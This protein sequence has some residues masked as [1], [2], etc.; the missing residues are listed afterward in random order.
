[1]LP[2]TCSKEE[3]KLVVPG[4]STYATQ[5]CQRDGPSPPLEWKRAEVHR[6]CPIAILVYAK[7]YPDCRDLQSPFL[8]WV[9]PW[10]SPSV[11]SLQSGVP[12]KPYIQNGAFG[13]PLLS[14]S[15]NSNGCVGY[16]APPLCSNITI[17]AF[18][19]YV[20]EQ[21]V[22]PLHIDL[23]LT[24]H[25]W[26]RILKGLSI[27]ACRTEYR[28]IVPSVITR[29]VVRPFQK[30]NVLLRKLIEYNRKKDDEHLLIDLGNVFNR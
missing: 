22:P 13:L 15:K 30:N 4:I 7:T 9:L 26:K 16:C 25:Q 10:I 28:M 6:R 20:L 11:H 14:Q 23:S 29:P 18:R 1:M 2:N 3:T 17:V 12:K 27:E 5:F 21:N 19:M 8:M 24:Q